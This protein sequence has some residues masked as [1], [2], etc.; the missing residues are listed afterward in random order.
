MTTWSRVRSW[1]RSIFGRARLERE[2]DQALTRLGMAEASM[3]N[4]A[5]AARHFQRALAI[6][7]GYPLARQGLEK[8]RAP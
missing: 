4:A 3:G 1:V 6:V 7:P 5:A 2:M 8:L